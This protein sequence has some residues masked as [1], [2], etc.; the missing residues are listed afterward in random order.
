VEAFRWGA[1]VAREAGAIGPMLVKGRAW[2]LV[3][4]YA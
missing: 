3:C 4:F 1:P 2:H